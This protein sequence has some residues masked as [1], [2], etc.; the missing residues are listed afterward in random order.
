M[1]A[2]IHGCGWAVF[3]GVEVRKGT[4]I[5]MKKVNLGDLAPDFKLIDTHGQPVSLSMYRGQPV[6]LVLT[7]GFI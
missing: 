1:P 6:V 3:I 4:E 7:R 2:G 5:G